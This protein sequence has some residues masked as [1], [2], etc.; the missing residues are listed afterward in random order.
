MGKEPEETCFQR[1]YSKGQQVSIQSINITNHEGNANQN[2][3]RYYLTH[4][5]M[6]I[7]KRIKGN[8]SWQE[9][10]EKETLVHCW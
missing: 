10:G 3:M 8:K 4:I 2:Y 1:R 5:R 7:T 9:C 6:A